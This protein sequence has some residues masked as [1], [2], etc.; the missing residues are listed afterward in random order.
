MFEFF[1]K[2]KYIGTCNDNPYLTLFK[3]ISVFDCFFHEVR[4][5]GVSAV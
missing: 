3:L 5:L 2:Y 1:N 4:R